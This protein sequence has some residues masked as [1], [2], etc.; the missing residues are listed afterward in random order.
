[1]TDVQSF[2]DRIN[3][4][5]SGTL[6]N[7]SEPISMTLAEING[8]DENEILLLHWTTDDGEFSVKVTEQNVR[9]GS[10]ADDNTFACEDSEGDPVILTLLVRSE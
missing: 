4:A 8:Q 3:S 9:E 1:M 2:Y 6:Y 7:V 5:F 10:W